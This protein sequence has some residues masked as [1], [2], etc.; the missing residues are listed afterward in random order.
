MTPFAHDVINAEGW[1]VRSRSLA[2]EVED[3]EG[4]VVLLR[5]GGVVTGKT[6]DA[7]EEGVSETRGRNIALCF[8]KFL[9]A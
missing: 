5:P 3:E 9:E 1:G 8:Q 6:G 2:L 7:V 4:N